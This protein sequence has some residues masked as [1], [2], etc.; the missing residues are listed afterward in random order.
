MKT[1]KKINQE[2][3]KI[4]EI[5]NEIKNNQEKKNSKR[6]SRKYFR[7]NEIRLE[8]DIKKIKGVHIYS[9]N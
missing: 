2:E 5:E 9:P 3:N 1:R 8:D 4:D 7:K 6:K